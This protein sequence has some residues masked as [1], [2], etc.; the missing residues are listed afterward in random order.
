MTELWS[1][2][3]WTLTKGTKERTLR[4][5]GPF[6]EDVAMGKLAQLNNA[7]ASIVAVVRD[8]SRG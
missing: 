8:N 5:Y 4:R 3:E 7:G 2:L 6:G 1:V